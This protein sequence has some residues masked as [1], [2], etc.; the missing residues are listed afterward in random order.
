MRY[1]FFP[2]QR[3][4]IQLYKPPLLQCNAKAD[5]RKMVFNVK[6]FL[7]GQSLIGFPAFL[8]AAYES[9]EKEGS[10]V[11]CSTLDGLSLEGLDLA[12]FS[13][14][15]DKKHFVHL[16][17]KNLYDFTV[18]REE[19]EDDVLT[20]LCFKFRTKENK[21]AFMLWHNHAKTD[22]WLEATP[23]SSAIKETDEQQMALGERADDTE[24]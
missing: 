11:S 18:E 7:T 24:E 22:I 20:I 14:E 15:D 4:K 6:M 5:D 19:V 21:G 16:V 23:N 13:N 8:Q 17:N 10:Q 2:T 1:E 12:M 9:V 3:R